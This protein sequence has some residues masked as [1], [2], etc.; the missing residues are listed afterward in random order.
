MPCA[1]AFQQEPARADEL[2]P[3]RLRLPGSHSDPTSTIGGSGGGGQRIERVRE[4]ERVRLED[5]IEEADR[6][7]RPR[8]APRR[9]HAAGRPAD[10]GA[11][12]PAPRN[13]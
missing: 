12:R 3:R 11:R 7:A 8:A 6:R 5:R 2:H 4:D 9:W 1:V 10:R 13:A